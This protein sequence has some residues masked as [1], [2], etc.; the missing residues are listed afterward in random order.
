MKRKPIRKVLSLLLALVLL[1][2][3]AAGCGS[4][5]SQQEKTTAAT[6]TA[7]QSGGTTA[8]QPTL[9]P[10]EPG[11]K[12]DTSPVTFQWYLHDNWVS[13]PEW[14]SNETTKNMKEKTGVSIE[15]QLNTAGGNDK[16]NVLMASDSLPDILTMGFWEDPVLKLEQGGYVYAL[17]EL[18]EK[19]DPYFFKVAKKGILD[20]YTRED[21]NVYGYTN[22]A[23]S[24]ED[25]TGEKLKDRFSNWAFLV[26][27][28]IYE[29]IGSPDMQTPEGFLNALKLAK[30]KFP[31]VNNESLIPF[32]TLQFSESGS[33]SLNEMLQGFLAIPYEKDGKIYDRQS[34]PEYV[35][36]LKVIRKANETGLI[37]R[38]IFTYKD[39]KPEFKKGRVF[40][41]LVQWSDVKTENMELYTANPNSYYIAIP[42]P[43]N[44]KKDFPIMHGEG[45]AGWTLG[46]ITK[47]CKAP[48]R[49]IR[50]F[51]YFIST[52]GQKDEEL[53][54]QG[55]TWDN[56]NGKDQLLPEIIEMRKNNYDE[57]AQ[58]YGMNTLGYACFADDTIRL[59][60]RDPDDQVTAQNK[61]FS[62]GKVTFGTHYQNL[63]PTGSSDLAVNYMKIQAEWG[64]ILPKLILAKSEEDF[65]K[66][67]SNYLET[68]KKY[69][70]D[71]ILEYETETMNTMKKKLNMN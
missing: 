71:Q 55:V 32:A 26:K 67:Y 12:L 6:S 45:P 23:T 14:G 43:A 56:I 13:M 15:W 41:G 47:K 50:L 34:D 27:K 29:A 49:A 48:D 46:F 54:K 64:K 63:W 8:A 52:E 62:L 4:S 58:K 37:N 28:D 5:G 16:I 61:S 22:Y 9:S 33:Y 31:K 3:V 42:G 10:D 18:A 38:D 25:Y 51:S 44:E 59:Q 35:K 70:Y 66:I 40:S 24:P 2:L 68:R 53:G 36:W 20:W 19:Y 11:Y 7:G 65:D 57:Y 21:G 39:H 1:G 17:N 69:N 60:W 30:E